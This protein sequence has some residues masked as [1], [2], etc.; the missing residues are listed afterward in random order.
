MEAGN[1]HFLLVSCWTALCSLL[2]C[3]AVHY[4]QILDNQMNEEHIPYLGYFYAADL[5]HGRVV[6]SVDWVQRTA[7][8]GLEWQPFC[9]AK[10]FSLL[11]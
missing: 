5:D 8:S 2:S 11:G 7:M 10:S 6:D 9:H 1:T 3:I 4:K